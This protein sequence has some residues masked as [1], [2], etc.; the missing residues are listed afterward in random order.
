[1]LLRILRENCQAGRELNE[2]HLI[3]AIAEEYGLDPSLV[4][5]R[6]PWRCPRGVGTYK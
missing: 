4:E 6:L 5:R 2:Q 1:M 3:N